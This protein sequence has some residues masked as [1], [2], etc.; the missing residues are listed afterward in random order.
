MSVMSDGLQSN[1]VDASTSAE[2]AGVELLRDT[3]AAAI[4]SDIV[5]GVIRPGRR[6][7]EDEIA[8]DHGVSRV[9]V[10]EALQKLQM[11]GY[12]ELIPFRGAVVSIP[13]SE[14][15]VETM[16]VRRG[17]EVI[18]ARLAADARGGKVAAQLVK[19]IEQGKSAAE[20][21]RHRRLPVMVTRF[22]DLVARA[23]GNRELTDQVASY[24]AKVEWMF[25]VD[26]GDRAEGE[27]ADHAAIVDAVLAGNSELAGRLMDK[28][29]LK[30]EVD[31]R[32][33]SER[34]GLRTDS[35]QSHSK[36]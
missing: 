34:K 7:R 28:H 14:Q 19:V 4:R 6:V 15:V 27:W 16:Q 22:H 36:R 18:A 17:L 29:V 13:S 33:M 32:K 5:A 30:D 9:P 26:L 12:V 3:I 23:S 25:A 2:T 10:R 35:R 21:H 20:A 31:Y 8:A 24:R 11:E 1:S